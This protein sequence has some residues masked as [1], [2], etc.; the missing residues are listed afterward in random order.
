MGLFLA[1]PAAYWNTDILVLSGLAIIVLVVVASVVL[2][3]RRRGDIASNSMALAGG[4]SLDL[5][6]RLLGGIAF[7]F[8]QS[9][10]GSAYVLPPF[11]FR[12]GLITGLSMSLLVTL[13]L[14]ALTYRHL[15]HLPL[16]GAL[17]GMVTGLVLFR[18]IF[19]PTAGFGGEL[20][21]GFGSEAGIMAGAAGGLLGGITGHGIAIAT[22]TVRTFPSP[23]TSD[24][25]T[26]VHPSWRWPVIGLVLGSLGAT[27][28]G[29]FG[30]YLGIIQLLVPF[31]PRT[32]DPGPD[33]SAT[34][35]LN[36]V[37]F[38]LSI[39][40]V[41]GALIGCFLELQRM[42][43]QGRDAQRYGLWAGAGLVA[44]LICGLGF[45]LNVSLVGGQVYI[46]HPLNWVPVPHPDPAGGT[47]GLLVGLVTGDVLGVALL[48]LARSP[49]VPIRWHVAI[50]E[51]SALIIGTLVLTFPL[52]YTP[53]WGVAIH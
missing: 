39:F 41:G 42:A 43:A 50:R 17:V 32:P 34:A 51:A 48:V 24:E 23:A 12:A 22:R 4:L 6:G 37:L 21:K 38:G 31:Y 5:S 30:A 3:L 10:A 28:V 27:L 11:D 29:A 47:R 18:L 20:D 40:A 26:F 9:R 45:G 7:V 16:I 14:G 8:V 46:S 2:L 44:G 52:W 25:T 33:L 1:P 36:D 49:R 19:G 15:R 13:A 53:F 35:A